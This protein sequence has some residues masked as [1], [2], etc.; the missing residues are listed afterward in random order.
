MASSQSEGLIPGQQGFKQALIAVLLAGLASFQALYATQALLP[1][2]TTDLQIDPATAALTVSATTGGLACA[3]IP[4]SVLSE[5][6]GRRN[7]LRISALVATVLGLAVSFAPGIGALIAIRLL[8]GIALA[9]VPAVAMAYL[10]EEIHPDYVPRFMGLYISGNTIGGLMG[11]IIPSAILEFA[12]WRVASLI[13]ASVAFVFAVATWFLLPKQRRFVPKSLSLGGEAAAIGRHLRDP[14]IL[15][16]CVLSFLFMGS[17]VSLYN[18]LGFRLGD[19]FGLSPALAGFVFVLYL[20]GTWSSA[21]AGVWVKTYS[22]RKLISIATVT[23]CIGLSLTTTPW[24]PIV[25]AGALV[26]TAS[27]FVAHSLASSA[28][29]LVARRDRAEASSLYLASYY[30]GSSLVGWVSGHI[31]GAWGWGALIPWLAALSFMAGATAV[32]GL[33]VGRGGASSRGA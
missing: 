9:G 16:L 25:I 18:Y 23:A 15:S 7:V 8:Q 19:R 27:F 20:S 28:V 31:F 21:R 13:S 29:G 10:S 6:F 17:F 2:F 1:V 11:R 4:L 24:I 12:D 30:V 3:I 33:G 32:V 5:K 22:R 26:F 14:R